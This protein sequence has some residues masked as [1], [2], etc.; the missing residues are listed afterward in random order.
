MEPMKRKATFCHISP[1]K[2]PLISRK[3]KKVTI[4]QAKTM[5]AVTN[6][7]QPRLK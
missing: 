6:C 3:P 5:I 2:V 4:R 1:D 7:F